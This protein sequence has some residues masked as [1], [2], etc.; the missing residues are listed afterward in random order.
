VDLGNVP[1]HDAYR[2]LNM[3]IGLVFMVRPGDAERT[4]VELKKL[5]SPGRILGYVERG[6]RET[7][8]V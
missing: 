4:L 1:E 6:R 2:T 3:G 8:L 5:K 7:K